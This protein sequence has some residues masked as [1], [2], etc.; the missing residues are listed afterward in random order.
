MRGLS[1]AGSAKPAASWR[2]M[3]AN[4]SATSATVRPI[5]P[6]VSYDFELGLTPAG[7]IASNV[8]LKPTMPQNAAGRSTDPP[9][10]VPSA[11]GTMKSATAAADPLEEPP[12]VCAVFER[13]ARLAG[14]RHRELGGHRL[15]HD[16]RA[17]V[18]EQRHARGIGARTMPG[19]DGRAVLRRHVAGVDDVLDRD[20]NAV[21]RTARLLRVPRACIRQHL[22]RIDVRPRLHGFLARR[23]SRETILGELDRGELPR[24][25]Q[26]RRFRG[27]IA[28]VSFMPAS[29]IRAG[30]PRLRSPYRRR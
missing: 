5:T 12:G 23:D 16:D 20:R 2:V 9:V 27:R 15:A 17:R 30:C 26:R 28:I 1:I 18:P 3:T 13:I 6:T 7:L 8:G 29:V 4:A 22:L 24:R 19:V 11:S 10:C 21:Q 14:M 25:D